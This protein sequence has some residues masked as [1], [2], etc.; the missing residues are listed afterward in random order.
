MKCEPA[1]LHSVRGCASSLPAAFPFPILPQFRVVGA[2]GKWLSPASHYPM[3]VTAA[4]PATLLAPIPTQPH[5]A[6]EGNQ[7]V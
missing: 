4:R 2:L 7:V 6:G 5:P 3:S 1:E